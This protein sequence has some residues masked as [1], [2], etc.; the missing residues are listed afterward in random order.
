MKNFYMQ[1]NDD[2]FRVQFTSDR[3]SYWTCET[4][5]GKPVWRDKLK[6]HPEEGEPERVMFG[7]RLLYD[8]VMDLSCNDMLDAAKVFGLD[9]LKPGTYKIRPP[10]CYFYEVG[11]TYWYG[12]TESGRVIAVTLSKSNLTI[13][14]YDK[15]GNYFIDPDNEGTR[16]AEAVGIFSAEETLLWVMMVVMR[17]EVPKMLK[18]YYRPDDTIS[19]HTVNYSE[20]LI[21]EWVGKFEKALEEL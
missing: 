6:Y 18:S 1:I 12:I 2:N 10:G 5:G 20:G 7:S 11:L 16:V 4:R 3:D 8:N 19:I 21:E 13:E 15:E 14:E 17:P 9:E